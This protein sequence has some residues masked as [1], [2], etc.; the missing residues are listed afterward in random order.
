MEEKN[1]KVNM[2][3]II[4]TGVASAI[5]CIPVCGSGIAELIHLVIPNQRQDRIVKYIEDLN[6]RLKKLNCTVESLK[7]KFTNYK[8]GVFT[9]DCIR[10]VVNEAYDEKIEYYKNICAKGIMGE[11]KEVE[12]AR[13]ILK[14]LEQIDY[15]EILF[16]EK[17]YYTKHL[18]RKKLAEIDQKLNITFPDIKREKTKEEKRIDLFNQV[19]KNN[20]LK[21]M[22]IQRSEKTHENEITD[23]GELLLKEMELI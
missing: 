4:T 17:Y 19:S 16:L 21:Q 15:S 7:N 1:M 22:L 18:D 5:G 12:E 14:I 11:E 10:S 9:Y 23:L 20:L 13:K 2:T 6:E 3:D 8:Y